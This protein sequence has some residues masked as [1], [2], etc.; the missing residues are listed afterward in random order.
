MDSAQRLS[1]RSHMH[2]G[3]S[4]KAGPPGFKALDSRRQSIVEPVVDLKAAPEVRDETAA[5][6]TA[7]SKRLLD[8]LP[9]LTQLN[10]GDRMTEDDQPVRRVCRARQGHALPDVPGSKA[11]GRPADER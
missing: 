8:A 10:A 11:R 6:R 4:A 7:V 1:A 5:L 3:A 9:R 2:A